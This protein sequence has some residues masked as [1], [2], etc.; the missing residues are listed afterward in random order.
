MK[1]DYIEAWTEE[2]G[3]PK[4]DPVVSAVKAARKADDEEYSNAFKNDKFD[5]EEDDEKKGEES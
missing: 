4:T 2:D 1:D 5:K 3:G